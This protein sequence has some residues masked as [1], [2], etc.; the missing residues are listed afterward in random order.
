[1]KFNPLLDRA[2]N[3]I[4][5]YQFV[6]DVTERLRAQDRLVEAEEQVRQMQ[7]MEAVG[8]L[9]GGIAHDFNNMMAVV[10]GGLNLLQRRLARGDTDVGRFIE[11]AMDGANRAAALTQRL[12]AFSRQQPLA[13][14]AIDANAMLEGMTEMLTRTLGDNIRVQTVLQPELW[15][16]RADPSQLENAILNLCVNA[17][18]AMPEGGQLTVLTTNVALWGEEAEQEGVEPGEYVRLDVT[19]TG[20]GMSADVIEKAFDPF[21]TTKGVGKGTGLGLSQVFGFIRQS[22]GQVKILSEL[23]TGTTVS[24]FLP[25][26]EGSAPLPSARPREGLPEGAGSDEIVM[27]VEDEERVRQFSSEALRELGY[28]VVET[29]NATEALR[30]IEAGEPVSL[31]FT[32]IMMPDMTGRQLAELALK[33]RPGLRVLFTT[34]YIRDSLMDGGIFDRGANILSKPFSI[35]QLATKVRE[36]LDAD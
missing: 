20:T 10:I 14:E 26:F 34:A 11:G 17:R 30:M 8:Q 24:V 28:R 6:H 19:D 33:A 12:L 29:R 7:K 27:V 31:V 32:D 23:G 16:S 5:A 2:G 25:R 3:R 35:E 1:M 4:G 22:G 13:P 18:D 9:T 15:R 36:V 21:F